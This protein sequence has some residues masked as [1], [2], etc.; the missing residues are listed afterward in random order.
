VTD[1]GV[2]AARQAARAASLRAKQA[3]LSYRLSKVEA[4]G[5]RYSESASLKARG[6]RKNW[7]GKVVPVKSTETVKGPRRSFWRRAPP[8]SE[9]DQLAEHYNGPNDFDEAVYNHEFDQRVAARMLA[10]DVV[11]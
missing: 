11:E 10:Q 1:P 3:K 8:K 5:Q 2:K 9:S 7:L 4:R 6:L